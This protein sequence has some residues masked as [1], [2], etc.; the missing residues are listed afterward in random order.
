[1]KGW[2]RFALHFRPPVT[3]GRLCL[4]DLNETQCNNQAMQEAGERVSAALSKKTE[5]SKPSA[6]PN[7]Q[8]KLEA[9]IV[10]SKRS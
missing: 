1:M 7:K 6:S 5:P 8:S 4:G 10:V 3:I 2:I 9:G